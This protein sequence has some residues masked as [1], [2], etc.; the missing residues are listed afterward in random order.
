MISL[1]DLNTRVH[2]TLCVFDIWVSADSHVVT[3]E[4]RWCLTSFPSTLTASLRTSLT[5]TCACLAIR[6]ILS[7][8]KDDADVIGITEVSGALIALSTS[9]VEVGVCAVH[10]LS[11]RNRRRVKCIRGD[12]I[13]V[14]ARRARGRL[15]R[16]AVQGLRENICELRKQFAARRSINAII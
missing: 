10:D 6:N 15:H 4:L 13:G 8:R 9:S 5:K 16:Q 1:F 3:D 11:G 7:G 12:E 14:G 2:K